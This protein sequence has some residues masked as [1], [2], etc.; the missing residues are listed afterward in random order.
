MG[1]TTRGFATPG[2]P[3]TPR[4]LRPS[5]A[6]HH[7]EDA[8]L[9]CVF[10]LGRLLPRAV[11]RTHLSRRGRP[12]CLT[13]QSRRTVHARHDTPTSD[14]FSGTRVYVATK[15]TDMR[16][17]YDTLARLV[18]DE[19]GQ[20]PPSRDV[21]LFVNSR[22]N[23]AKCLLTRV[24]RSR[25]TRRSARCDPVLARASHQGSRSKRGVEVAAM[26]YSQIESCKLLDLD[27]RRYL[28]DSALAAS[29]CRCRTRLPDDQLRIGARAA[30]DST[31]PRGCRRRGRGCCRP[32]RAETRRSVRGYWSASGACSRFGSCSMP[33][34]RSKPTRPA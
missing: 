23:R 30:T 18:V 5:V 3:I 34:K 31:A 4:L 28:H 14:R 1:A 19:L 10:G 11:P 32:R 12:D 17:P 26:F 33:K 25:A 29:R 2:V 20:D 6:R 15:P 27:P 8:Q 24:Y 9:S 16:K 13:A 21:F 7:R 22:C